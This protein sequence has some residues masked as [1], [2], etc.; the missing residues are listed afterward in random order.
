MQDGS[1][2]GLATD[3]PIGNMSQQS[4]RV[5]AAP[6]CNHV[7]GEYVEAANQL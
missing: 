6:V 3:I 5:S 4:A 1:G 2:L 7:V